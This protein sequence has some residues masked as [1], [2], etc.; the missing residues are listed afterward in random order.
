MAIYYSLGDALVTEDELQDKNISDISAIRTRTVFRSGEFKPESAVSSFTREDGSVTDFEPIGI[1][2]PLIVELRKIYT[3]RHPHRRRSKDLLVTSAM[4]SLAAFNGEPRAINLMLR[5]VGANEERGEVPATENGTSLIFYSPALTEYNSN[6]TVEFGFDEFD[7]E[8]FNDFG[9]LFTAAA[10]IPI[11]AAASVYLL[12]AGAV[13]KISGKIGSFFLDKKQVF[14]STNPLHLLRG[15]AEKASAGFALMTDDRDDFDEE[16][17]KRYQLNNR[18]ELVDREGS[19]Y[20]GDAPYAVISYDGRTIDSYKDFSA[21]QAS[22]ELL[23]RFYSVNDRRE[24]ASNLLL[25]SVKLYN[26]YKF[27]KQADA[28]ESQIKALDANSDSAEI[29]K[30]SARRDAAL[31]NIVEDL[32]KP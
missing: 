29:E 23:D 32:L 22:A 30:L 11:F 19:K 25:D 2:K 21:T 3:G 17:R 13:T 16:T 20:S 28:F 27:R 24:I 4:K 31:A 5:N 9:N 12:A 10:G 26:D 15:G 18:G 14:K 6:I 1:G 8:A 7:D